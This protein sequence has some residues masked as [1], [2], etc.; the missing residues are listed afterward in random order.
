MAA[1][2]KLLVITPIFPFPVIGA[3]QADRAH[4]FGQFIRLGYDIKIITKTAHWQPEQL[5]TETAAR[6]GVPVIPIPYQYS[7][8]QMTIGE[9]IK[10]LLLKFTHPLLLDGA[11][12]EYAEPKI[13]AAVR[14]ELDEWKPDL[15]WFDYTYLWPLYKM[16]RRRGIPIIT[17][18][19]NFEPSHFWQEDGASFINALKFIPKFF[20]ELLTNK[21]SDVML[22]ITPAEEKVYTRWGAAD[23][24]TLP[25]RGL[26]LCLRAAR[27]ARAST[28]LKIFFMGSTYNVSHNR[29]ALEFV[30]KDLAPAAAMHYPNQFQFH[31][32]GKKVPAEFEKYFNESVIYAGAKYEKELDEF[33]DTMDVA[34][35]PSFFGAG[36][37]QKIFEPLSRGIPLITFKRGIADYPFHDGEHVLFAHDTATVLAALIR[38]KDP[39]LRQQL[40]MHSTKLASDIFS[41][42]RI[43]DIVVNAINRAL[44][45]RIINHG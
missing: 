27:S 6:L 5:M 8:K 10:K 21:L 37:Q 19:I 4:G 7:N 40:S 26:P 41:Q 28:P 22:A 15:V 2:T 3:E 36:M 17:R 44:K 12:L 45:K 16:V 39:A 43:D 23:C 11:A 42:K 34:L 33:L 29:R 20:G 13:Q 24:E 1:R 14:K 35:I 30:L 31:V 18:S 25:L 38:L 9:R 32:L